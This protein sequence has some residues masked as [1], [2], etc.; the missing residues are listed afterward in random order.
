LLDLRSH[1]I[2]AAG[3]RMI[4]IEGGTVRAGGAPPC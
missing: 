1:T 3:V 4:V 2:V